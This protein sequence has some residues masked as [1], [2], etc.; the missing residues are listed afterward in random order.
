MPIDAGEGVG[1]RV[2]ATTEPS[3]ICPIPKLSVASLKWPSVDSIHPAVRGH[4][5]KHVRR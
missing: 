1:E 3:T 4:N 5:M 2:D